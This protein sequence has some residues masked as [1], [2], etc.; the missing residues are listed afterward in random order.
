MRVRLKDLYEAADRAGFLKEATW[1]PPGGGVP[2][3]VKVGFRAPDE[4]VLD[5]LA[6]STDH[7]ITYPVTA[8][9][10]LVAEEIVRIEAV[11]FRVREVRAIRGRPR[12]PGDLDPA[13]MSEL[14]DSNGLEAERL[15][16]RLY[17]RRTLD[18]RLERVEAKFSSFVEQQVRGFSQIEEKVSN[19]KQALTRLFVNLETLEAKIAEMERLATTQTATIGWMERLVWIVMAAAVGLVVEALRGG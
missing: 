1:T 14:D 15:S 6:V 5:W 16:E 2:L 11:D 18:R 8:L 12:A 13:P 9:P 10:D 17:G 4:P 3:T 7:A 19:M